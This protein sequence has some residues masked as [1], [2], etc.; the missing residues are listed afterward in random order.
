MGYFPLPPHIHDFMRNRDFDRHMMTE[1]PHHSA[2]LSEQQTVHDANAEIARRAISVLNKADG[3]FLIKHL[4]DP[5]GVL[6]EITTTGSIDGLIRAKNGYFRM[7][8]DTETGNRLLLF[9]YEGERLRA[10]TNEDNQQILS[11][12]KRVYIV[13]AFEP[14][15]SPYSINASMAT[16]MR[17]LRSNTLHALT[18]YASEIPIESNGIEAK[19]CIKYTNG[20]IAYGLFEMD[21]GEWSVWLFPGVHYTHDTEGKFVETRETPPKG[22]IGRA[23]CLAKE[24]YPDK[25]KRNFS[26]LEEA[27]QFVTKD[28]QQRARLIFNGKDPLHKQSIN[29]SVFLRTKLAMVRTIR[30]RFG[31]SKLR[32]LGVALLVGGGLS[33]LEKEFSLRSALAG[34][35]TFGITEVLTSTFND[36]AT[37]KWE[38][39]QAHEDRTQR[40]KIKPIEIRSLV[41]DYLLDTKDNRHKLL[42]NID[43]EKVTGRI[44]LLSTDESGI[45]ELDAP[46]T[47]GYHPEWDMEWLCNSTE[48]LYAGLKYV[49]NDHTV[50]ARF[51]NGLSYLISNLEEP[52]ETHIFVTYRKEHDAGAPLHS[53]IREKL[54]AGDIRHIILRKGVDSYRN[55]ERNGERPKED[56]PSSQE[57]FLRAVSHALEDIPDKPRIVS[58]ISHAFGLPTLPTPS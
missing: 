37:E 39:Y 1:F 49:I 50:M 6:G 22:F 58:Y 9:S 45:R 54:E 10:P 26:N 3:H 27:T 31:R 30:E 46:V 13:D 42:K 51:P 23:F 28:W 16:F 8:E 48:G 11:S 2:S 19:R 21:N 56:R 32:S 33:L 20:R 57:E 40:L 35:M 53:A 15:V 17:D 41:E 24:Q 52:A 5:E 43:P 47:A 25:G 34:L 55:Y 36:W 12:F 7:A 18:L 38:E 29:S 44:K 14:D 4:V